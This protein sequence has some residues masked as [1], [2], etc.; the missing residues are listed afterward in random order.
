[1]QRTCVVTG[2]ASGIGRAARARL[3]SDGWRVIG[4]DL[5]DA[6]VIAD[7]ARPEGRRALVDEVTRISG[8]AIDGVLA[9]AGVGAPAPLAVR[10][11]FF[12]AL[13][14][15]RGLQPLLARGS[16][17]RAVAIASQAVQNPV[18]AAIVDACLAGDEEKAVAAAAASPEDLP[19]A[20]TKRALARWIR[21]NASRPEWAG[22]G[23]PLN[24]VGPGVIRT[25]MTEAVRSTPDGLAWLD[26]RVPMPLHGH[27]DP[28]D[29][30]PL[31]AWLLSRENRMVTGQL[32]FIDGG[33]DV[34]LRGDDV[35]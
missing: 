11:N 17:P 23:I 1:V 13:A 35:W 31:L 14:T 4:V 6:E 15:L 33:S 25:P 24:A 16:E 28:E 5:R 18:D 22:A 19:Y 34:I 29:V 2:S 30:A 7:L 9:G 20:S 10:V 21:R 12:G 32:I 27:G 8:G 26:E 3:E